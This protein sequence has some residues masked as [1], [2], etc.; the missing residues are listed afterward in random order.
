MTDITYKILIV[1]DDDTIASAVLNQVKG[2]G[3]EAKCVQDFSKVLDTFV[4]FEPALIL[5]DITLPFHNGFF[6]CQEIRKLW[7]VTIIFLSSASDN[8]NIIMAMNMGADDFIAKPFDFSVLIA[9]MQALLRRS[10]DFSSENNLIACKGAVL[11]LRDA[12][13]TYQ[14]KK[15]ELT[16]NDFKILETLFSNR[17]KTVSRDTLM[18]KLWETDCYVD[19]N[20]LTVNVT[21]LRRK[22]EELGL[23]N[24]IITKKGLGYMVE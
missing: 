3:Y 16:K 24:F 15:L 1:E 4:A 18:T 17:G 8:M 14:G 10:Y 22:L 9:K 13:L 7:K 20:T 21:R 6:W 12:S 5:L 23:T 11:N 19:E 2:W